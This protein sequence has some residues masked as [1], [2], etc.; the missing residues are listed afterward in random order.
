MPYLKN[1]SRYQKS[2]HKFEF[3]GSDNPLYQIWAWSDV[4]WKKTFILK[5]KIMRFEKTRLKVNA[6]HVIS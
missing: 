3:Y 5:V 6:T 2:S 4:K 1:Q